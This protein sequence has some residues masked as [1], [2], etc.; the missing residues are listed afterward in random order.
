MLLLT[1]LLKTSLLFP[2]PVA[3]SVAPPFSGEVDVVLAMLEQLSFVSEYWI[4]EVEGAGTGMG[5]LSIPAAF[6]PGTFAG[7][8]NI[9]GGGKDS[10]GKCPD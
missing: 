8:K 4:T 10:F 1:L 5:A 3:T 9:D 6:K 2:V 7:K